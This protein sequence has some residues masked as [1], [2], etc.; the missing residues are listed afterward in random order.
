MDIRFDKKQQVTAKIQL[1]DKFIKNKL[2]DS[3][4]K[5]NCYE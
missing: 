1:N 3:V 5:E 4:N 2:N